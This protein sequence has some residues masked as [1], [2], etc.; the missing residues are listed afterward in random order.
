MGVSGVPYT[1][2]GAGG[3]NYCTITYLK[4]SPQEKGVLYSGSDDG[5]VYITHN[6][7]EQWEN[8]SPVAVKG[9]QI[10]AI[11]VS[12]HNKATTYLAVHRYKTNDFSPMIFKTTD[13]GKTWTQINEGIPYGAFVRV[14]REDDKVKDLL[15]AGT[16]TG[17][18]VSYDG[19]LH[20]SQLQLNLP[21]TPITDLMV[22]QN[23]LLA[24]TQG[25][26]FWILDDL[27]P[28]REYKKEG[29]GK[30]HLFSVENAFR[31]SGGSQLDGGNISEEMRRNTVMANATNGVVFYY[32]IQHDKD[33]VKELNL[34]IQNEKG[35]II[36][37]FHAVKPASKTS[38]NG[39]DG[40][41][42]L[43]LNN[44]LNRFVW[45]MRYPTLAS[46]PNVFI[47]GSYAG[48]KVVPGNYKVILKYKETSQESKFQILPDP[49]IQATAAQ[50]A[51]QENLQKKTAEDVNDIHV[52][53]V[54]MRQLQ[55]Q[56]NSFTESLG[57][58]PEADTILKKAK[59]I[60]ERIQHWEEVLIQPKSQSNDDV[61]NFVNKLSA[62]IIFLR[63]ELDSTIPNVTK[64]QQLRY[65]ELHQEW[66]K[67]KKEFEAIT[68]SE[69]KQFN[70][71]C[72]SKGIG[73]LNL[74]D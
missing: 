57:N 64:G 14:V 29:S 35:E 20:W 6:G 62:N 7:G 21:V 74:K 10:N 60:L 63:W 18:Y 37:S 73:F 31:V 23:H 9:A 42:L 4:E 19:G 67:S 33:S 68:T 48:G 55:Q 49:R 51:E 25:R 59:A 16:E 72:Q 32:S 52:S 41:P 8:I 36:R 17:F 24:S 22:H 70:Q 47:E 38:N 15:Y 13:Y 40:D 3:E 5:M 45:D 50:Y 46:I 1:N 43:T 11:E 53:V 30:L 65:E 61:I 71:L 54:R 34:E 12:P 56:L 44:G 28:I 58:R 66:L 27:T 26:A 2:E 39:T 69:V